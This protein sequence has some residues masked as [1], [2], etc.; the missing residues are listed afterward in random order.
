MRRRS[1]D[2]PTIGERIRTRRQLARLSVRQAAAM[3]GMSHTT[4][5]RIENGVISADNRFTLARI[6]QVL[7]CPTNELTGVLVGPADRDEA[8]AS[9]ATYEAIRALIDADL[10]YPAQ[11]AVQPVAALADAV[12]LIR[13][14]RSRCDFLGCAR[15][16]AQVARPLHAAAID[17]PA[18]ERAEALRALVLVAEAGAVVAK[19][20]G[21]QPAGALVAER[22]R[23]AAE[24]LADPVMTAL[25]G[26]TVAHAALACGLYPRGYAVAVRAAD[27]LTKAPAAPG[28]LEVLGQLHLTAAYSLYGQGRL[29]D[30]VALV[31]EAERIAERTGD[32]TT[33]NLF[34][35]PANTRIWRLS[36]LTDGG[37]PGEAVAIAAKTNPLMVESVNRQTSFYLDT[38]RALVHLRRD[39][40]AVRMLMTAERLAP[41]RMRQDPLAA[42]TARALLERSRRDAAGAELRGLCER[43]GIAA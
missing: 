7:G 11:V 12:A 6:A 8:A 24:H 27:Q 15:L 5:G 41:Q 31:A 20:T 10:D 34:F 18:A 26:W 25:A 33:L 19:Y 16:I 14:L 39:R 43:M 3:A 4:W 37:D 23:Q 9:T 38:G 42:E 29:D 36:M 35:G 21:Q 30:A 2:D 1:V 17:G 40:E 32:T 22:A 28:Q 13:D